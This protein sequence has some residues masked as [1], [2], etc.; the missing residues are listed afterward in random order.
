MRI[1][2][3]GNVGIGSTNPTEALDLG[4]SYARIHFAQLAAPSTVTDKLYN[5][6]GTLY[7]NGAILSTGGAAS[8]G[9]LTGGTNTTAAMVVGTGASLTYN[10]GSV[11]S[12]SINA[13]YFRGTN[14]VTG[15]AGSIV[16]S[17]SPVLTTPN[18]GTPS[19]ITL[20]SGTGLPISTG[21][22]GLGS[23]VA[24][25]LATPNSANLATVVTD[26]TGTAGSLVFSNSPTIA[27][28]TFTT[29]IIDPLMIGSTS[30]N[31]TITFEGNNNAS[32][33]TATNQNLIFNVGNS[34]G[35]T[36]M[37]ILNNGN[38]GIGSTAATEGLD[39]AA[40]NPRIH[41]AQAAA[42]GVTTDKLYNVAGTL[43]WNGNA[44]A[45]GYPSFANITAGISTNTSMIVG[46]ASSLS[47]SGSGTIAATSAP[48]S[49]L[50]AATG[51]V[52]I[53]NVSNTQNWNWNS[54]ST[55]NGL[56]L[57]SNSM[58]SGNLLALTDSYNN[59]ASTGNILS[60]TASG[61]SNAA[62]ALNITNAGTGP[63]LVVQSGNV[64]IG[65]T[66]PGAYV[67]VSPT[68]TGATIGSLY[69]RKTGFTLNNGSATV[70]NWYGNYVATPTV[71]AGTLTNKYALV[72]EANAGNVGIGTLSPGDKLDVN[73]P[74]LLESN[75]PGV[76]TNKLYNTA[77]TLYW[78]GIT[79]STSSL[80]FSSI[81]SGSN[82]N[83][84][85]MTS[86]GSL[87]YAGGTGFNTGSINANYFLNVGT[88]TGTA[89]SV[90][91]SSGPTIAS[92]VITNLAP[93]ADFTITQNSVAPFTSINSG[94]VAN[95]LYL[96]TGNVGVGSTSP[97][98]TL[99]V[100]GTLGVSGHVTVETVTSTGATG[101]GKFVFDT[102]PTI[103][104]PTISGHPVIEGV[105]STGATGTNKFVFDT[106]PTISAPTISGHPVIEG[107]TSTGATG[108]GKFVFDTSPTFTTSATAPLIYG[109]SSAGSSLSLQ[110]TST[111]G[112]TD[113]IRFLVGNSGGTE[114]MRI[115]DSGNIG[116][117]STAPA[118][119]LDINGAILL[120]SSSPGVTTNKLYNSSG[121]LTWNGASVSTTSLAFSNITGGANPNALSIAAG[122]SLT[123]NLGSVVAGAINANYFQGINSVTGTA[124]SVVL[125]I[126]PTITGHPTIEG[127]TS[128]GATGTGKFVFDTSPVISGHPQIEGIT[129][130][131]ATGTG[132]FVFDTT[133]T[134]TTSITDPLVIGGTAAGASL[135]L[136]STTNV[137]ASGDFIKFMVGN[138][139]GTEAMRIISSGN[140]GIGSTNP[141]ETLDLGT[142]SPTIH[143]AQHA[144]PGVVADKLYN[145]GGSLYW[146]GAVLING[147][148]SFLRHSSPAAPT[149]LLPWW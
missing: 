11:N 50:T 114:A 140:V 3:S 113:F 124:G 86:P 15:S 149:P 28:P 134:F 119:K 105:T 94:A 103:S 82:A 101:T 85:S 34:G 25:F 71:S 77:G 109:G 48:L 106:S 31:G 135:A 142:S 39:I 17:T 65:S 27:T 90:V 54:L 97:G 49:G 127:I 67:D 89:G 137:S 6:G 95:T 144:A 45:T 10:G 121:T 61:A 125:S 118:E 18:L 87:T 70:T 19:A 4:G 36:G 84:L 108:T 120:E 80:I 40:A 53:D 98:K 47:V 104:A 56:A 112:I 79:V 129:S 91:F 75:T 20:T 117:G 146:N 2:S 131:G 88:A 43:T 81:T 33:N 128:T 9:S 58:T 44:V 138:S 66:A 74:I 22:S 111:T 148:V 24:T 32:G 123:Y 35:T 7:W 60:I 102:S 83:T 37:A 64:G 5:V 130:T 143:F 92:P 78:N 26:K 59:S 51:S 122:G 136:Q 57:G 110:S 96:K 126:A 46:N 41:I 116:I 69:G 62:T 12:G 13:D 16:L 38:V 115:I 141:V 23:N 63:S 100:T 8:F 30:A 147:R 132:K 72:T 73:G 145:V 21:V 133:P 139:G 68:Y 29:S 1:I 52:T 93:G 76:T 55:Q 14:T 107:V 42:P 99:D